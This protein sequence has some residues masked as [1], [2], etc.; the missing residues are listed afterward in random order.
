MVEVTKNSPKI[1]MLPKDSVWQSSSCNWQSLFIRENFLSLGHTAWQGFIT[2]GQGIVVCHLAVEDTRSINWSLDLVEYEAHFLNELEV[3]L[4][5]QLLNLKDREI[6]LL[7]DKVHN[8]DPETELILLIK[9]DNSIYLN[10]IQNL[11]ISPAECYQQ[12]QKRQ[13][14]F[15]LDRFTPKRNL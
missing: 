7:V 5:L 6:A 4:Y 9:K 12:V 8:Y 2:Q 10:L 14:E 15:Q 11:A 3:A 13:S 1:L